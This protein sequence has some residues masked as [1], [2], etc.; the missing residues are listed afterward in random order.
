MG[1]KNYDSIPDKYRPLPHRPNIVVTRNPDFHDQ[2]IDIF[3]SIEER[4]PIRKKSKMK[5]GFY[6]W[7]WRNIRA[8]YSSC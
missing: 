1:R 7:R 8:N 5:R 6:Y 2:G 4:N 3:T